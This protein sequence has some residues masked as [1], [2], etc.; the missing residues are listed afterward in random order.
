MDKDRISREMIF[1]EHRPLESDPHQVSIQQ[2]ASHND[3]NIF[4]P[5]QPTQQC[6]QFHFELDTVEL[7]CN[8][9]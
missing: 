5:T 1:E 8:Q 4:Q 6:Q 3:L 2:G 7:Q 9:Q